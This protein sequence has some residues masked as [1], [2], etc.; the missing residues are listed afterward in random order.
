[1]KRYLLTIFLF[2]F[3]VESY[4]QQDPLYSQYMFNLFAINPAY[5]GSRDA[6]SATVNYRHQWVGFDGAP[7]TQT[8]TVHAPL[9]GK[10]M[11]V[12]LQVINDVIG[13]KNVSGAMLSYAYRIKLG[14]GKLSFGLRG[15]LLNYSFDF[16]K[17]EYKDLEDQILTNGSETFM[18]PTFDFGTF[19]YTKTFYAGAQ[20][21][22]LNEARYPILESPVNRDLEARLYSHVS[23]TVGKAFEVHPEIVLKPSIFLNG[24]DNGMGYIDINMSALFSETFWVGASF[25][26]GFG[27]IGLVEMDVNDKLRIGYSYGYATNPLRVAQSGAHEIFIGYDFNL[28]QKRVAS[29]R[30]F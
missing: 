12:G 3:L 17:I 18:V 27:V 16:N 1:M 5:A 2:F 7:T 10:N 4:A 21:S 14:K 29:P 26:T 9:K 25:R 24:A 22:H 28:L 6:V 11:G 8:V 19:Y 30:Y 13:P 20:I 15:G 23:V